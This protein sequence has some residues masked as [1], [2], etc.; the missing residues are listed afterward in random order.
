MLLC[1]GRHSGTEAGWMMFANNCE[2][3]EEKSN[4]WVEVID[5]SN[6]KTEFKCKSDNRIAE[7]A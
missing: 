4:D 3:W 7:A 6:G 2:M 5:L 1:F